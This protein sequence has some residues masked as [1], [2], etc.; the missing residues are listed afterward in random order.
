MTNQ[1]KS[2]QNEGKNKVT[3]NLFL[4]HCLYFILYILNF[5]IF[6]YG[7]YYLGFSLI[8]DF[9]KDKF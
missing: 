7:S 9:W 6:F 1:Q 5:E 8:Y 4:F 2:F 3:H